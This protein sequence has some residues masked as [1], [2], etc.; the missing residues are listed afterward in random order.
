MECALS[1]GY[2]FGQMFNFENAFSGLVPMLGRID[3]LLPMN[4]PVFRQNTAPQFSIFPRMGM[5][6]LNS[7]ISFENRTRCE[8]GKGCG[9]AS[10]TQEAQVQ[11]TQ[12]PEV[13]GEVD[14][15]MVKRREI[16]TVREQMRLAA[17]NDDFEKAI[18][19]RERI[20]EMEA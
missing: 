20:K 2:D 6:R 5:Q 16:N 8:N 15:E 19:L 13:S 9:C 10:Q 1:A 18:E 4:M 7:P 11:E 12:A 17:E 3:G 14:D